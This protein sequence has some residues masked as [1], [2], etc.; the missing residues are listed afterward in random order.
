MFLHIHV[1]GYERSLGQYTLVL[2]RNYKATCDQCVNKQYLSF[3]TRVWRLDL[4]LLDTDTFR[5]QDN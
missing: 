4:L 3:Q 2:S 1:H 5:F